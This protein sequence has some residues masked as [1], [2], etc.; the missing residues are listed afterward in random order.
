MLTDAHNGRFR[1]FPFDDAEFHRLVDV[2]AA[3]VDLS[4]DSNSVCDELERRLRPRYPDCR[5]V[6]MSPLAAVAYERV[7][8]VYR[9]G[10]P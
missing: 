8:Y 3:G 1:A 10:R 4:A 6:A 7:W 2:E 5:V 9:D